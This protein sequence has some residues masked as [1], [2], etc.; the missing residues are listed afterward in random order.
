M[1]LLKEFFE[2]VD[3]EKNHQTTKKSRKLPAK[4]KE[5]SAVNFIFYMFVYFQA[6]PK[7]N[8]S[9]FS[10]YQLPSLDRRGAGF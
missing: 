1:V 9:M 10:H 4:D 7:Q 2:K 8:K 5:L 3:F 6:N